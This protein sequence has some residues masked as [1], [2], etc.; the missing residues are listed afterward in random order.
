VDI[1]GGC[2]R[3]Y[4]KQDLIDLAGDVDAAPDD[5]VG[6]LAREVSDHWSPEQW[7]WLVRRFTPRILG[8]IRTRQVDADMTRIYGRFY[9]NLATWPA[10]ERRATEEALHAALIN[11][12]EHWP[13]DDIVRLLDGLASVYDDLGQWL[14]RVDAAGSA[15]ARAGVVRLAHEWAFDL[16]TGYD[17]WFCS[18]WPADPAAPVREW[19]LNARPAV[20]RFNREHPSCKTAGD[21]LIAMDCVTRAE[22]L[23]WP[24]GPSLLV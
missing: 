17:N 6:L 1:S 9:A 16:A 2:G 12:L 7:Q 10:D 11:A 13:A 8:L 3:C 14:A 20:E 21:A 5:V 23:P 4:A 15:A 18:W 19:L 22:E 24:Y